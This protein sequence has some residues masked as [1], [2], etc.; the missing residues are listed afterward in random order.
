MSHRGLPQGNSLST[1]QMLKPGSFGIAQTFPIIFRSSFHMYDRL[2]EVTV[3]VTCQ[4]L[5]NLHWANNTATYPNK[6]L[7]ADI[8]TSQEQVSDI[9]SISN[10]NSTIAHCSYAHT[11]R[12][13][14][15]YS[16]VIKRPL[17]F[18]LSSLPFSPEQ[19]IDDILYA[20]VILQGPHFH[21]RVVG[22]CGMGQKS[23]FLP[24]Y[25]AR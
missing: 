4:A 2:Y 13:M 20:S 1:I 23:I 15:Y 17:R 7:Q 12:K 14:F 24:S 19:F 3:C 18:R 8:S 22:Q 9:L 16:P 21:E 5:V 6:P 11:D 25:L 10:R